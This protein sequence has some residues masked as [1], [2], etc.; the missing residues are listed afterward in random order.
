MP[1][2]FTHYWEREKLAPSDE[3]RY[4]TRAFSSQFIERGIS[5]GDRIFFVCYYGKRP[6]LVGAITAADDPIELDDGG[7]RIDAAPGS[8]S[9]MDF[10]RSIPVDVARAVVR[11]PSGEGLKFVS[12]DVLSSQTLRGVQRISAD[13]ALLLDGLLGVVDGHYSDDPL[14]Y[15]VAIVED[16]L[17][18]DEIVSGQTYPE[19]SVTQVLVNRYE[20]DPAARRACLTEYGLAC[21][22]CEFDF[23]AF[24]GELGEGFIHVHHLKLVSQ[25]GPD[26]S[27]DPLR[28]LIPVCPNCHAMLHR[29]D[30]PRTIEKLKDIYDDHTSENEAEQ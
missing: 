27:I 26:Y 29:T 22:V 21:A 6:Y 30:P 3:P 16:G 23:G 2:A 12:E 8:G 4:C 1:A 17:Y 15:E 9:L 18:P 14:I 13:S 7:E 25:I 5:A 11:L 28:D 24:Y 19:G 20:R 10:E